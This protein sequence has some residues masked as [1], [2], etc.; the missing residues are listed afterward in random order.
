MF[1]D[2]SGIFGFRIDGLCVFADDYVT[3]HPI[4]LETTQD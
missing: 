1:K 3:R 2:V 4:D